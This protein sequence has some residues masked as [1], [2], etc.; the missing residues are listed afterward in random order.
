MGCRDNDAHRFARVTKHYYSRRY[1]EKDVIFSKMQAYIQSEVCPLK[2]NYGVWVSAKFLPRD[3][4]SASAV[5]P[6]LQLGTG[7]TDGW[8]VSRVCRVSVSQSVC[9]S[10]LGLAISPE[11]VVRST[12]FLACGRGRKHARPGEARQRRVYNAVRVDSVSSCKLGPARTRPR[13][14]IWL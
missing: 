1:G 7:K 13:V 6:S 8:L 9:L 11:R 12:S 10:A 5:F 4:R 2:S 3:A 14:V